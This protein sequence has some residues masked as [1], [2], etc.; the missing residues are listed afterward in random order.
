MTSIEDA[1]TWLDRWDRQQEFYVADREERFQVI[2]D[3]IAAVVDRPDPLIVDLGC[4]PGSL[5]A[6]LLDRFPT[7]RAVAV[8]ADPLLLGLGSRA[9]AD[10]P[11]LQF[12]DLDL[13]APGW[14]TGLGLDRPADAV[15]STTAL[16]WLTRDELGRV[17]RD[18]A[19][20]LD[21][22]GVFVN[23]DHLLDRPARPRL[24]AAARAVRDARER[25]AGLGRVEDWADWW[26]AVNEA[27][28]LAELRAGRSARPIDHTVPDE[29]GLDD[30]L[31]LLTDAGFAEA[32]LVWAHGD[33]RVLAALR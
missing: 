33:D 30:H 7:A 23:G 14:T 11:G 17:Y 22:H 16:H 4:G 6:R 5:S 13:R 20:L 25:R 2:A 32:G 8:D 12:H 15:V 31:A 9:Y 21:E 18:V 10:R 24:A 29:P 27:P 1:R 3:V 28:E 26:Q 19:G